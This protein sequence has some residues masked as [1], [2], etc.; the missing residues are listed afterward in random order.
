MMAIVHLQQ[1]FD[2]EE[3]AAWRTPEDERRYF[4]RGFFAMVAPR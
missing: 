1:R 4:A 2:L 3:L